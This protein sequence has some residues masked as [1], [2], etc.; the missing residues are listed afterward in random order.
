M[1][2][3]LVLLGLFFPLSVPL[4]GSFA[5]QNRS[6]LKPVSK[7]GGQVDSATVDLCKSPFPNAPETFKADVKAYN[8]RKM[9]YERLCP[10]RNCAFE[11]NDRK[12]LTAIRYDVITR[13][14]VEKLKQRRE[15]IAYENYSSGNILV[16]T[17][18]KT[19]SQN[20][21]TYYY[22]NL[23]ARRCP[24][25]FDP[26]NPCGLFVQAVLITRSDA[27][28]NFQSSDELCSQLEDIVRTHLFRT[29]DQVGR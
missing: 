22:I 15:Q 6:E 26:N 29:I 27:E 5:I 10:K 4:G 19:T 28:Q 25:T 18:P 3:L 11:V 14:L 17:V 9:A 20:Q 23:A 21:R 12:I 13:K 7:C 1:L 24:D 2:R 16:T 8:I